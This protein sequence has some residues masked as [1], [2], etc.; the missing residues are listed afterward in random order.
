MTKNFLSFLASHIAKANLQPLICNIDHA[1]PHEYRSTVTNAKVTAYISK[2]FRH[3]RVCGYD[4]FVHN[5]VA[6]SYE[7]DSCQ[8]G[9]LDPNY[10]VQFLHELSYDSE[11]DKVRNAKLINSLKH[12]LA[13]KLRDYLVNSIKLKNA[14]I[15]FNSSRLIREARLR[16]EAPYPHRQIEIT[17]IKEDYN[18]QINLLLHGSHIL[19]LRCNKDKV[20]FRTH[21][22]KI[23]EL[24]LAF[25]LGMTR[26]L[27]LTISF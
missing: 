6:D 7:V 23:K 11:E 24:N 17:L 9:K 26:S 15:A 10:L 20:R 21:K 16:I 12:H 13:F 18:K 8:L 1:K 5:Q 3:I 27:K 22:T 2:P 25:I 4:L 19:T 14:I